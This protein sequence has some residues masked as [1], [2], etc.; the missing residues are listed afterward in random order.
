LENRRI[1][2]AYKTGIQISKSLPGTIDASLTQLLS[3]SKPVLN[4]VL[5]SDMD[6]CVA[7]I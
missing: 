5:N 3:V 4:G 6:N 1:S 7:E 2:Q